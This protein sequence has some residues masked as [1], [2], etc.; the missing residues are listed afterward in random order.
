MQTLVLGFKGA[1]AVIYGLVL[2]LG[3][4]AGDVGFRGQ[5][6]VD[7][8]VDEMDDLL[9]GQGEYLR[10]KVPVLVDLEVHLPPDVVV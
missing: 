5:S 7:H 8:V 3:D 2:A 4:E 6:G 10:A 1:F 9:H